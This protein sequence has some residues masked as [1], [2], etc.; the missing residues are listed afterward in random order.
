MRYSR[1]N[2]TNNQPGEIPLQCLNAQLLLVNTNSIND[3]ARTDMFNG[4]NPSPASSS[5][6]L[7]W[8]HEYMNRNTSTHS[9]L[10]LP[11]AAAIVN[12]SDSDDD[13]DDDEDDEDDS[14]ELSIKNTS[15]HNNK[16]SSISQSKLEKNRKNQRTSSRTASWSHISTPDSLEWDVNADDEQPFRSEEDLLDNETMELLQEIEW[17]KNRALNETGD[18][19]RDATSIIG[20]DESES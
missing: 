8:E 15:N 7:E 12:D 11:E 3:H 16:I 17:L 2:K 9:W 10:A 20:A 18:S 19:I 5:L 13:D 1:L 6:D 14:S 4:V